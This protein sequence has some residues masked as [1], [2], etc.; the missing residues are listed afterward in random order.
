MN[1][2]EQLEQNEK[3]DEAYV[4]YQQLLFH[5]KADI[6]LLTKTA[7]IA[8]IYT[9]AVKYGKDTPCEMKIVL[10]AQMYAYRTFFY[11]QNAA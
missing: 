6:D 10:Y 7:H 11:M 4:E 8:K 2:A 9:F 1:L 5:N 3:Y